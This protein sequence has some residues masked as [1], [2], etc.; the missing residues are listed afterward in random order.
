MKDVSGINDSGQNVL[1]VFLQTY[2]FAERN[3]EYLNYFFDKVTDL[4]REDHDGINILDY[5][6]IFLKEK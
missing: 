2:L 4:K 6:M 3:C 5:A 1:M